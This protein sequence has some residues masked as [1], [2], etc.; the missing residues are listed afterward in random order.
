[1]DFQLTIDLR[2]YTGQSHLNGHMSKITVYFGLYYEWMFKD[3][4][5]QTDLEKRHFVIII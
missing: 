1:M 4:F 3:M 5:D 2:S